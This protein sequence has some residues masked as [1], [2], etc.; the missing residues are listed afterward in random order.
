MRRRQKLIRQLEPWQIV[1]IE[2]KGYCLSIINPRHP[3]YPDE[4]LVGSYEIGLFELTGSLG[5]GHNVTKWCSTINQATKYIP[6]FMKDPKK[7]LDEM[8]EEEVGQYVDIYEE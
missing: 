8:Y 7:L 4:H 1:R 3:I 2:W 6:R 5:I